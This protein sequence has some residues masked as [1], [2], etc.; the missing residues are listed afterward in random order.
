METCETCR[1]YIDTYY[2]ILPFFID[3]V[4]FNT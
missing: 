4:I 3:S 2:K 1:N